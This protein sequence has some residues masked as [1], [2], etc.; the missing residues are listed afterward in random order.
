[1]YLFQLW[2][3]IMHHRLPESPSLPQ[4]LSSSPLPQSFSTYPRRRLTSAPV[5]ESPVF[6]QAL[7]LILIA[8]RPPARES[9]MT[10]FSGTDFLPSD[11]CTKSFVRKVP[12]PNDG[13][14][15]ASSATFLYSRQRSTFSESE[16]TIAFL[17]VIPIES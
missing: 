16:K 3:L 1:M 7:S 11:L 15:P 9:L 17:S 2:S 4:R 13:A 14:N 6:I 8:G 10:M 12:T 5:L